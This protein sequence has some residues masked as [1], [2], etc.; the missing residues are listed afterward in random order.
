M[1]FKSIALYVNHE[2]NNNE[3]KILNFREAT[4]WD[5]EAL[6]RESTGK[7]DVIFK[8][9]KLMAQYFSLIHIKAKIDLTVKWLFQKNSP[10]L[11][12]FT[13]GTPDLRDR[14]VGIEG[15]HMFGPSESK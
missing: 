8:Y 7:K 12:S 5:Y 4:Y 10:E 9:K 13:E 6:A 2:H 14:L 1:C 3:G 15:Y 11:I